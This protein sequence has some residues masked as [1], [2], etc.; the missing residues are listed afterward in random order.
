L[1]EVGHHRLDDLILMTVDGLGQ[2]VE[3]G[4]AGAPIADAL[5]QEGL[6]LGIEQGLQGIGALLGQAGLG[7]R[8][9]KGWSSAHDWSLLIKQATGGVIH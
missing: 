9:H 2:F 7:L 3:V 6:T 5:L 1:A 8:I 4:H